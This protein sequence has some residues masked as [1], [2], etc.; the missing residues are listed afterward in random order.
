M[1]VA[2]EAGEQPLPDA[3]RLAA[4]KRLSAQL[5]RLGRINR[6]LRR[7]QILRDKPRLQKERNDINM[8]LL[9]FEAQARQALSG[10]LAMAPAELEELWRS[11]GGRGGIDEREAARLRARR[12]EISNM[13]REIDHATEDR[14]ELSQA[15]LVELSTERDRLKAAALEVL[16]DPDYLQPRLRKVRKHVMAGKVEKSRRHLRQLEGQLGP[17]LVGEYLLALTRLLSAGE[18]EE[19]RVEDLTALAT[20]ARSGT[21]LQELLSETA[22]LGQRYGERA[23]EI[24]TACL[25]NVALFRDL[26][27]EARSS[28][29]QS[30]ELGAN[31]EWQRLAVQNGSA[32]AELLGLLLHCPREALERARERARANYGSDRAL[33]TMTELLRETTDPETIARVLEVVDG[34]PVVR[35]RFYHVA[36]LQ[37]G[38]P[39]VLARRILAQGDLSLEEALDFRRRNPVVAGLVAP[40]V[41]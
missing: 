33:D 8:L 6:D 18:D 23:Q 4:E 24:V 15:K 13:L 7:D 30:P 21:F 35:Y 22:L 28:F 41:A 12:L 31:I 11:R 1:T 2:Y 10:E 9:L 26:P 29:W 27:F 17:T 38:L 34:E 20:R 3:A 32:P 16:E 37:S 36:R 14:R 19:L 25:R 39:A 5:I 40:E